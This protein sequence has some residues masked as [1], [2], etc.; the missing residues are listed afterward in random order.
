MS[1]IDMDAGCK[2]IGLLEKIGCDCAI[3]ESGLS[4][5]YKE[6]DGFEVGGREV[7]R[8]RGRS[9]LGGAEAN[10]LLLLFAFH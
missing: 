5:G 6:R 10:T 1:N 3:S 9:M 4:R 7:T 2:L 8:D